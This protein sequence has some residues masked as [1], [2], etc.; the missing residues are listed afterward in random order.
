M[1]K[2]YMILIVLHAFW[3]VRCSNFIVQPASSDM[4]MEDFEAA[5]NR[6]DNVYPFLEFKQIDWDSLYTIYRRRVEEAQ[7][8]AFYLVLHDLLAE[9]K[10][11]HVYYHTDG[12]GEVYPFYPQRHF[13]DRHAYSPFVV[14]SYFDEPLTVTES[15]SAEYGI[16]PE[17]IGYIFLSDFHAD[18]LFE[19]FAGVIGSVRNTGGLIIDIRQ[20]KGGNTLNVDAVVSRFITAPLQWPEFV[21]LGETS[22]TTPVQPTGS[23]TYSNPVVVLI[24]GSTFSAGE[25]CTEML[26]QCPQVTAVGDTTGG[27]GGA[28]SGSV[29]TWRSDFVLPSGKLI[30]TPTGYVARYDGQMIEW[31]GVPPDVRIVNTEAE[32]NNGVD[33]QLEYAIDLLR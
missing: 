20:K 15:R 12:G 8:D 4:H 18:Y 13:R 21:F 23:F 24:N 5:W 28:G 26:K 1:K 11:G 31:L 17:N 25:I 10:D 27:G 6:I 30:S 16:L 19:E 2:M 9:L 7:G 3:L 33:R 32:I 22:P 14:R 29:D